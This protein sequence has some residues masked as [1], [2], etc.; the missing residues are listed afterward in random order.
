[1]TITYALLEKYEEIASKS[2]KCK[3]L[4]KAKVEK[5]LTDKNG[6]VNGVE[7]TKDGKTFTAYG[8]VVL[9]TGGYGAD[10]S[11]EGLLLK[12]RPELE[13]FSTTNGE[14]CTGDGIK[15]SLNVGGDTDDLSLV[16][17]H[18][19]GLVNPKEPNA[20]VKFLAAEALRGCGAIMLDKNG[21]RFANELGR[22]DYVSTQMLNGQGPFRL[23]L[24]A[25]AA[26]K[27][28]WHCK[29][30]TGRGLMKYMKDG[31][32]LANEMGISLSK[33]DSSRTNGIQILVNAITNRSSILFPHLKS[34]VNIRRITPEVID[35]LTDRRQKEAHEALARIAP[36]LANQYPIEE[37][38]P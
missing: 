22:R 38:E 1:M 34:G 14:H 33:L 20:K 37:P 24:N 23:I 25:G 31:K 17:V 12:H 5:L 36:E 11:K 18:P 2:D 15:M 8:P 32:E 28:E 10:F 7:Y 27:I 19:T 29:H 35:A 4:N 9:A 3:L 26:K 6:D 30:Y 21:N 13:K 16:Q